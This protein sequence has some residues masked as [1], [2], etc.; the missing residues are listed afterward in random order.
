MKLNFDELIKQDTID[1]RDKGLRDDGLDVL[2]QIIEQSTVL[3][4]LNLSNNKLTL[5]DG[6]LAKAKLQKVQL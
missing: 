6:K 1:L 2:Y 4:W 3:R 5:S